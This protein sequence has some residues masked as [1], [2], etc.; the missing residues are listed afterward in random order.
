EVMND[1]ISTNNAGTTVPGGLTNTAGIAT[2]AGTINGG[3]TIAGGT[4]TTT[5]LITGGLTNAGTVNAQGTILG[6][7]SNNAGAALNLIGPLTIDSAFTNGGTLNA[8]R[9]GGAGR[10]P[11][12]H[13]TR[14]TR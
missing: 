2:N 11:R 8:N 12:P 5:N 7:I 14:R 3:A 9:I 4:L 6:A 13:T 10:T 1:G